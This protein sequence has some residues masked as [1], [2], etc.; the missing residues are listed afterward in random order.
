MGQAKS[1]Q[2]NSAVGAN[3]SEAVVSGFGDEWHRFNQCGVAP[4]ELD[5]LFQGY[6]GI[7]PWFKLG[8]QAVGFDLGCGS[9]RWAARVAPRV[10]RLWCVDPSIEALAVARQTLATVPNC[11][12]VCASVDQ[13]PMAAGSMDFGYALGVLHHVPD[14]LAGLRACVQKLKPGAPFLVYF[15]YALDNRPIWFRWLWRV[16]D[17]LRQVISRLPHP[18]R[19]GVSQL[20]AM[21]VYWPLAR[22][23]AWGERRLG[24]DVRHWPLS[25]YRLRSFYTMRTDA[26]DRFGTRLEWRMTRRQLVALMASAGLGEIQVSE[27]APYWVAVGYRQ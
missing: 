20:L 26:L 15:Y 9:G 10:G 18:I 17:G 3:R 21:V 8:A 7:F 22:A 25:A 27:Q 1:M 12:F 13:L 4:A 16:S 11:E 5:A 14:P 6:F 24:K 19:Y 23:A 2:E